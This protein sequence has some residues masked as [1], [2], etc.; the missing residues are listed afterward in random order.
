[1]KNLLLSFFLIPILAFSQNIQ[2]DEFL[3]SANRKLKKEDYKILIYDQNA[4]VR[5]SINLSWQLAG[6]SV[7][8]KNF[9]Q[10]VLNKFSGSSSAINPDL[11]NIETFINYQ[12]LNFDL[13]EVYA[14]KMR[15]DLLANKSTFWKGFDVAN[16]IMN[17]ISS[18]FTRTQILMDS[19]T[20]QGTDSTQVRIWE[21][22]IKKELEE[23][24]EFDYKNKS[25][26]KINN[27]NKD[28]I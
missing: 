6:F 17:Q 15:R 25:K 27:V 22:K 7:F 10:N 8:N 4:T 21:Q 19:E 14:R 26:I 9:N 24:S 2:P 18:D 28:I 20:N 12:Q 5:S 1:M 16:Q 11:Y 13:A 23:L 3:W